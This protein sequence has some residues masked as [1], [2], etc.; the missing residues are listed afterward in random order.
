MAKGKGKKKPIWIALIMS[1]LPVGAQ[2]WVNVLLRDHC[3]PATHTFIHK[4]NEP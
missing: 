2:V 1:Y 3:L 4:W